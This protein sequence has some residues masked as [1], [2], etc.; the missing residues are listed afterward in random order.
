MQYRHN[1]SVLRGPEERRQP[2]ASKDVSALRAEPRHLYG[3]A[4]RVQNQSRRLLA[5]CTVAA[6]Q[7]PAVDSAADSQTL[8]LSQKLE[9]DFQ[10]TSMLAES[11]FTRPQ[12]PN[13]PS[14]PPST[15]AN[16]DVAK[17]AHVGDRSFAAGSRRRFRSPKSRRTLSSASFYGEYCDAQATQRTVANVW[18][19]VM[20]EHQD[21]AVAAASEDH[22]NTSS[23][24]SSQPHDSREDNQDHNLPASPSDAAQV[25]RLLSER[26]TPRDASLLPPPPSPAPAP[27]ATTTTTTTTASDPSGRG[28]VA[29]SLT[30]GYPAWLPKPARIISDHPEPQPPQAAAPV[31]LQQLN[32]GSSSSWLSAVAAAAAAPAP[33]AAAPLPPRRVVLYL[34]PEFELQLPPPPLE[35]PPDQLLLPYGPHDPAAAWDL[36]GVSVGS[37]ADVS[38]GGSG[39][40][41]DVSS[42]SHVDPGPAWELS[43]RELLASLTAPPPEPVRGCMLAPSPQLVR[44][45]RGGGGGGGGGGG[46][47]A[48]AATQAMA[49]GFVPGGGGGGGGSATAAATA[50]PRRRGRPPLSPCPSPSSSTAAAAGAAP[51]TPA[52]PPQQHRQEQPPGPPGAEQQPS[53]SPS[54]PPAG[55]L[56]VQ[57]RDLVEALVGRQGDEEVTEAIMQLSGRRGVTAVNRALQVLGGL[58]H[59]HALCRLLTL[60]VAL[61]AANEHTYATAFRCLHRSG[62][63]ELVLETFQEAVRS[64]RD[65]GPV[66]CSTLLHIAARERNLRLAWQLFDGMVAARMTL[67]RYSYNCMAHAAAQYGSLHDVILIYNMMKAEAA[68]QGPMAA[69]ANA[70]NAASAASAG[71]TNRSAG[72]GAAEAD[73]AAPAKEEASPLATP[74][75]PTSGNVSSSTTPSTPNKRGG[76][77]SSLLV[78]PAPAPRPDC[79]PDS[80]TFSALVR[81]A[82]LAGRGDLLPALFNE[83]AA[84]QRAQERARGRPRAGGV[85]VGAGEGEGEGEGGPSL[86]VWGH[87]IAAASRSGQPELALRFFFSGRREL[88]LTPNTLIYNAVLAAMAKSRPLSEVMAAYREMVQGCERPAPQG[89]TRPRLTHGSSSPPSSP[90]STTSSSS[91]AATEASESATNQHSDSTADANGHDNSHDNGHANGHD[92]SDSDFGPTVLQPPL[93]PDHYTFNA[94]LT[95]AAHHQAPLRALDFIRREMA[96]HGVSINMHIGASLINA[97]RKTP[98]LS[99]ARAAARPAAAAPAS[100]SSPSSTSAPNRPPAPGAQAAQAAAADRVVAE[101]EAVLWELVRG[102]AASPTGYMCMAALYAAAGRPEAVLRCV[103]SMLGAGMRVNESMVRFLLQAV[104]DAELYGLVG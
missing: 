9:A 52:Q 64:G 33:T 46:A 104:E 53:T 22:A 88:G 13:V 57:Q 71:S 44:A 32:S 48:A 91:S 42:G 8:L 36:L 103:R 102:G 58:G 84:V 100:T 65:L 37:A 39:G 15:S 35:P 18:Q 99:F 5:P 86:E 82:D 20:L 55:K 61:G 81:A 78:A 50:T 83:M 62:R 21:A 2:L 79:S 27:A 47:T 94:L 97:Y 87:F 6:P 28:A 24:S 98:E 75:S 26:R 23:S 80:Y 92:D 29:P 70:A 96:R 69:A 17:G 38:S 68:G 54:A 76:G 45:V 12:V 59:V 51:S 41:G 7:R 67:N 31:P 60:Q 40:G 11:S 3:G 56:L 1:S 73:G 19:R 43:E 63:L 49:G 90:A 34:G 77:S 16:A 25:P 74:T 10:L 30:K 89:M 4:P 66:A 95:S 72:E 101:A 14:S 93:T 85:V